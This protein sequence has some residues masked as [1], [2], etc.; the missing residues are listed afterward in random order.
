MKSRLSFGVSLAI[1]F[2]C[3]LID[4]IAGAGDHRFAVKSQ[5]AIMERRQR[6]SLLM[7]SHDWKALEQ[8]CDRFAVLDDGR[9]HLYESAVEMMEA[10]NA[11]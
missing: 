6:G 9:L 4:E 1:N 11:L 8:Y 5:A 7:V 2:D 10:Y 3:I